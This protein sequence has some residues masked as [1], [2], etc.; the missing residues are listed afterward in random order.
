MAQPGHTP[1]ALWERVDETLF[2][3]TFGGAGLGGAGLGG[4]GL[5]GTVLHSEEAGRGSEHSRESPAA[6]DHPD[7]CFSRALLRLRTWRRPHLL[8]DFFLDLHG[9][10]SSPC[11]ARSHGRKGSAYSRGR[12]TG[13][14]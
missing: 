7:Q 5:G 13:E 1:H 10:T 4:A 12:S 8:F 11:W 14:S 2:G 6:P 3:D 9:L